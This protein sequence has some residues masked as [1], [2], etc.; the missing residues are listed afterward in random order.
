MKNHNFFKSIV[1][2][3]SLLA[4]TAPFNILNAANTAASEKTETENSAEYTP[5]TG[6]EIDANSSA[7]MLVAKRSHSVSE[8]D[9]TGLTVFLGVIVIGVI[10]FFVSGRKT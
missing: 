10:A 7:S 6:Y 2:T 3:A 1:L 5:K 4:F 9:Q 8:Q